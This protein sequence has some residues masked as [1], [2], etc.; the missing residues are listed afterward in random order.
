[1]A[2]PVQRG[3]F[4]DRQITGAPSLAP[5]RI[6]NRGHLFLFEP[7]AST[8]ASPG[9]GAV[10]TNGMSITNLAANEAASTMTFAGNITVSGTTVTV[11]SVTSGF[12]VHGMGFTTSA[13]VL[14]PGVVSANG[15]GIGG[16]GTYTMTTGPGNGTYDVTGLIAFANRATYLNG[17]FALGSDVGAS[18]WKLERTLQ[19]GIHGIVSK[20]T[21][22]VNTFGYAAIP[23]SIKQWIINR[24]PTNAGPDGPLI[25]MSL[26]HRVTRQAATSGTP[27]SMFMAGLVSLS[28]FSLSITGSFNRG[29]YG[30]GDATA[31]NLFSML[32][33]AAQ[34]VNAMAIRN[35]YS[36]RWSQAAK[37]TL[38]QLAAVF[39]WGNI[40]PFNLGSYINGAASYVLYRLAL[41]DLTAAGLSYLDFAALSRREWVIATSA[42]GTV[43]PELV[44]TRNGVLERHPAF[45]TRYAGRYFGDNTPTDPA[46]IS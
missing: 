20:T 41:V 26:W 29:T 6:V 25:G 11:N 15:T 24:W 32:D 8:S 2:I 4:S 16:T 27:A 3:F 46:T 34:N 14:L 38:A 31:T 5:D 19:G 39:G 12:V 23:D 7:G 28:G 40:P 43:I 22:T 30:G 44:V 21:D 33:P 37:P 18:K 1:M 35:L 10:P 45:V 17:V 13:G 36:T 42:A 9:I